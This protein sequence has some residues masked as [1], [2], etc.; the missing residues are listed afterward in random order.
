MLQYLVKYNSVNNSF[1]II[2]FDCTDVLTSSNYDIMNEPSLTFPCDNV[3]VG[4]NLTTID[5]FQFFTYITNNMLS[6]DTSDN[7]KILFCSYTKS[8]YIVHN[9]NCFNSAS[10]AIKF[11]SSI[12]I[13]N[14]TAF[15]TTI[16]YSANY[17]NKNLIMKIVPSNIIKL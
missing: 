9:S 16:K 7:I 6:N 2:S 12:K 13:N 5:D 11:I 14:N 1:D 17:I 10:D 8:F 15:V 4:N 3:V